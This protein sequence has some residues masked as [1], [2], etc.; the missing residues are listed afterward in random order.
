MCS[1]CPIPVHATDC[2]F[3]LPKQKPHAGLDVGNIA[4]KVLVD[5][6]IGTLLNNAA[7]LFGITIIRGASL[8]DAMQVVHQVS[9]N[10]PPIH[11]V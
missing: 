2:I 9:P 11:S 1:A 7:F 6:T 3:L 8:G 5:Q 10:P 4:K